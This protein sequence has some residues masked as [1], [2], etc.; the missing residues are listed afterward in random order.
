[1]KNAKCVTRNEK[2][3][4]DSTFI[5]KKRENSL[6]LFVLLA[7]LQTEFIHALGLSKCDFFLS[8]EI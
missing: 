3:N 7:L 2:N 5:L 1:M 8:D 6:V 4:H